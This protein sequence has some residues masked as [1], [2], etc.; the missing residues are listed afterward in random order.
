M[1]Y[2]CVIIPGAAKMTS[3]FTI[4]GNQAFCGAG[5]LATIDGSTTAGGKTICCKYSLMAVVLL[6]S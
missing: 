4:I 6:Y 2:D 1:G 3:P 5:G